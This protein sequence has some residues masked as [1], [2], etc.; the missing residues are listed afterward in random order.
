MNNPSA[1]FYQRKRLVIGVRFV[2]DKIAKHK[3]NR[4]GHASQAMHHN[5]GPVQS[6]SDEIG[7]LIEI[8]TQV[9]TLMVIRWDVQ[10]VRNNVFG[11]VEINS[12]RRS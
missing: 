6:R 8:A 1:R 5:V 9:K 3:G 11:E 4:S 2:L 12:L 10:R 7:S